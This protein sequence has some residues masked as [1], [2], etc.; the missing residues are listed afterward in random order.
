MWYLLVGLA[1]LFVLSG[2][3][4]LFFD[5]YYWYRY[6][7]R[8][9]KMRN[10]AP[11]TYESLAG[12]P[13]QLIAVLTPCWHEAGVIGTMLRHNC[14]AIDY[15]NYY[16]FVGVYPNDPETVS[17]VQG[18]AAEIPQV[19]CVVGKDNGPTNKA[20]NLN[21]MFQYA[22]EFEKKIGKQ[23]D[24]FVFHD[25][26]DIIHP[27]SFK[28]YNHL[29][30]QNQMIQ[31]PIFPLAV[32]I[33]NFTHWLYADEFA[34]N[35]TKD[36]IV[37]ES[38]RGHVP[39]AGVGTAFT[40]Q[41]LQALA[42]PATGLPFSTSSLTEDYRTSL[43]IRVQGLRQIFVTRRILK[44]KWE[45]KG[46]FRKGYVQRPVEEYIATRALFPMEYTK[47]VRQKSRWI[48]GIVFQEWD[49]TK[50]PSS[51]IIR[52][53]LAH[54]RKSFFTHIINGLGYFVLLYWLLYSWFTYF[55]P[56]YPSL[57][58]QLNMHS[59]V[60]WLVV[61]VTVVMF[62]RLLQRVIAV[63]RVYKRWL[64]AL[65]AFPRAFYGNLINLHAA[66]RAFSMYYRAPKTTSPSKQPVWDKTDH[67]FPG[68]HILTPYRIK[69]GD[70][71]LRKR[72]ISPEN[73]E[74]AVILQQQ[75]GQRLGEVF[76]QLGFLSR[77][78][79]LELLSEQY[80]LPLKP[81]SQ[82][83]PLDQELIPQKVWNWLKGHDVIVIDY[84]PK[85]QTMTIA[86][87]DPTNEA[88]IEKLINRLMP[89]KINFVLIDSTS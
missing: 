42:D 51:W 82:I 58:E 12:K 80:R 81:K 57:Q 64:P 89:Y 8:L 79:L 6:I 23:F 84:N 38:I 35:H 54:D 11:L 17:E 52:Y 61:F 73:L 85:K 69:L 65:L 63:R 45:P 71:L 13:E 86:L 24:I 47:A 77:R 37:R 49:H 15:K 27:M 33:W 76:E 66:L 56:A 31:I 46:W 44:M 39:S 40:R 59:W 20:A 62:E 18:V 70:M 36:I 34:E 28:L 21:G 41:V 50:W 68:S 67:H 19:Q 22:L 30:P 55:N 4:D 87:D 88:F 43:A 32:N 3:D 74:K 5:L 16:F 83:K 75:T 26:E 9:F 25:S 78:E 1:I 29:M 53:T 10:F 7:F 72:K 2:I 48:I 60:W 14:Y